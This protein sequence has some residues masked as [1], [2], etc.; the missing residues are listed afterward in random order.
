MGSWFYENVS[1][2]NPVYMQAMTISKCVPFVSLVFKI[3]FAS[4]PYGIEAPIRTSCAEEKRQSPRELLYLGRLH[5][6]KKL[7]NL[8]GARHALQ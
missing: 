1:L 3:Q 4:I 8:L 2:R 7:L 6:K 5:K